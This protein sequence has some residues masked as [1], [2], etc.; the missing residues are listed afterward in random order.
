MGK[1]IDTSNWTLSNFFNVN[2]FHLNM[3][4]LVFLSIVLL[5]TSLWIFFVSTGLDRTFGQIQFSLLLIGVVFGILVPFI[6][7]SGN[8]ERFRFTPFFPSGKPLLGNIISIFI[9]CLAIGGLFSFLNLS[10]VAVPSFS[11]SYEPINPLLDIFNISVRFINYS[12][13]PAIT[14]ELAMA[15]VFITIA[16]GLIAVFGTEKAGRAVLIAFLVTMGAFGLEHFSSYSDTQKANFYEYQSNPSNWYRLHGYDASGVCAREQGVCPPLPVD[17]N[18]PEGLTQ[19]WSSMFVSMLFRALIL[20]L[21]IFLADFWLM[22]KAHAFVN[23]L[24]MVFDPTMITYGAF[25]YLALVVIMF[26]AIDVFE[27]MF[28]GIDRHPSPMYST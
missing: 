8:K 12:F 6:I 9:L 13:V 10:F 27:N 4:G 15:G 2:K 11:V 23:A 1:F 24:L 16:F 18:L 14:E 20:L 26:F 21:G 17:P 5:F 22:V 3:G 19:I 25:A 28:S 7:W